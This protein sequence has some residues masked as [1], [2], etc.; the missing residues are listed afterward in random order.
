MIRKIDG[1]LL[2]SS[3]AKKLSAFYSNVLGLKIGM[4]ADMGDDGDKVYG[5]TLKSGS[6]FVI[7]DHSKVKGKSIQPERYMIN[8]EVDD[9]ETEVKRLKSAKT[10]L[11]TDIYHIE[12]YGRVATFED[13]DGNYFQLVQVRAK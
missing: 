1:I 11:V 4:E 7:M 8:F 2:S 5:F 12:D 9:I 3:D 10:K 13:P 6:D